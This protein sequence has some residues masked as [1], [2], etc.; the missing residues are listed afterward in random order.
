MLRVLRSATAGACCSPGAGADLWCSDEDEAE[1]AELLGCSTTT[2]VAAAAS[3]A[4][5]AGA[6]LDVE[7][8]GIATERAVDRCVVGAGERM[9][10]GCMWVWAGAGM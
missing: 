1:A 2:V 10:A 3:G 4:A 5:G 7:A 8:D 6:G 9:V